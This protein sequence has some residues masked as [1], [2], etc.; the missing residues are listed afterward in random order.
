MPFFVPLKRRDESHG[1]FDPRAQLACVR[2]GLA[3]RTN[4]F[5]LE[6]LRQLSLL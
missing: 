1:T 4:I 2:R 6:L 5:S 3:A